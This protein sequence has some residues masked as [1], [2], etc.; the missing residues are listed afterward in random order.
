MSFVSLHVLC[1][2]GCLLCLYMSFVSLHVFC[3]RHLNRLYTRPTLPKDGIF[4]LWSATNRWYVV[5]CVSQ[6][7]NRSHNKCQ[8][9]NILVTF[10]FNSTVVNMR[11]KYDCQVISVIVDSQPGNTKN[12]EFTR[13]WLIRVRLL[14]AWAVVL[15]EETCDTCVASVSGHATHRISAKVPELWKRPGYCEFN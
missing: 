13:S 6:K 15:D 8:W 2:S 3:A 7:R 1:V 11:L 9:Y 4:P 12:R 14:H 5:K 10:I